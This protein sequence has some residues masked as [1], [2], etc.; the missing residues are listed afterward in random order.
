MAGSCRH[1]GRGALPLPC[2]LEPPRSSSCHFRNKNSWLGGWCPC[3]HSSRV[4]SAL[5]CWEQ[6]P[7][8][9]AGPRSCAPESQLPDLLTNRTP[10]L[11]AAAA[12]L[13]LKMTASLWP[14]E[15]GKQP[16]VIE[17]I[18]RM[19]P[20]Q[21][22]DGE[23]LCLEGSHPSQLREGR[24]QEGTHWRDPEHRAPFCSAGAGLVPGAGL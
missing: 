6:S 5:C 12:T 1:F 17:Q 7:P 8:A 19:L 23:R 16:P 22:R 18:R 14:P 13:S 2:A 20:E 11:S 21:H 24:G 4:G 3:P 10:G 15:R 9:P